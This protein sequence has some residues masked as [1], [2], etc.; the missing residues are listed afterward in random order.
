MRPHKFWHNNTIKTTERYNTYTTEEFWDYITSIFDYSIDG[1]AVLPKFKDS[2]KSCIE[3]MINLYPDLKLSK[4]SE[5]INDEVVI[6]GLSVNHVFVNITKHNLRNKYDFTKANG[7]L[8]IGAGYG[9]LAREILLEYNGK[10]II[11]DLE[12][13]LNCSHDFLKHE[14][15]DRKH[16]RIDHKEDLQKIESE[17]WDNLYI[18]CSFFTKEFIESQTELNKQNI[19]LVIN[20]CSLGEMDKE[21]VI[22]YYNMVSTYGI[23]YFYWLNRYNHKVWEKPMQHLNKGI[24]ND[25]W[26][27]VCYNEIPKSWDKIHEDQRPR[28][29]DDPTGIL[30]HHSQMAE[31]FLEIK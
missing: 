18:D 26:N 20:T 21:S 2:Q 27:L 7:I 9:A 13:S 3:W 5:L 28:W 4:I 24:P 29:Y 8:E 12:A 17:N 31:L 15:P 30:G 16:L 22:N 1:I 6:D 19:D 11:I 14:F 25:P 23:K 10:Y